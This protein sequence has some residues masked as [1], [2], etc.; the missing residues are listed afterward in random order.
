MDLVHGL[1]GVAPQPE[2][3]AQT[4]TE[5]QRDPDRSPVEESRSQQ[6]RQDRQQEVLAVRQRSNEL[7]RAFPEV[8]LGVEGEDHEAVPQQADDEASVEERLDAATVQRPRHSPQHPAE[9]DADGRAVLA[10][11][12]PVGVDELVHRL[13]SSRSKR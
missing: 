12:S 3:H 4:G 8:Q 7:L 2:A 11:G 13:L 6:D 10:G 5:C 9:H 1:L